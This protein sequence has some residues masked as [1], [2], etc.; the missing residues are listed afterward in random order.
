MISPI[1]VVAPEDPSSWSNVVV[2][3]TGGTQSR[4]DLVD[5]SELVIPVNPCIIDSPEGDKPEDKAPSTKYFK[6]ASVGDSLFRWKAAE[7]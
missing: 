7:T 6:P 1:P 3:T 2:G 4:R 5:S